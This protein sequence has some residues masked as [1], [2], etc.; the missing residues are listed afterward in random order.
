VV[1]CVGTKIF[2]TF[3]KTCTSAADCVIGEHMIS[4]CGSLQFIGMNAAEQAR[5]VADEA[6]CHHQ[7]FLQYGP[8][9]GCP[10]SATRAEDGQS[11]F[12]VSK[13]VVECQ[14]NQC[15]TKCQSNQCLT[16][17]K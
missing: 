11:S 13:I 15:L 7:Y 14:S 17:V 10:P 2:P 8:G 12:D 9:G 6:T 1:S 3:D 5:F 4:R 16:S